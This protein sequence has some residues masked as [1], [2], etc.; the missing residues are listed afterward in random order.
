MSD[1]ATETRQKPRLSTAQMLHLM[2]LEVER[3]LRQRYPISCL[4]FGLDGFVDSELLLHRKTLMPLLFRELKAVTFERDI[5][6][7]GIWTEGFVL[8]VFP[9][10]APAALQ[11]LAQALLERAQRITAEGLPAGVAVSVSI[12]ISHNLH[13]GE[14]S[15]ATLVEDAEGGMGLARTGG[16]NRVGEWRAVETE[17]DRL[18]VELEHQIKEIS[19]V[20]ERVFAGQKEEE[21]LWGRNLVTKVLSLFQ[22]DPDQSEA[23]LRLEKE[24]VALLKVELAAWSETSSASKLLES[25]KQIENLERRITKLTESLSATEGALKQIAAAKNID[26]GVASIF[27]NV[28]GLTLEDA[29]FEAKREMLKNIFEANMALRAAITEK[30]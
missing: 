27:R 20:Q 26:L 11:E 21:D 16:G 14:V 2:R 30:T 10:V 8:A 15:F 24:V 29:M 1:T 17:L 7:L 12:G 3:A 19:A 18:K 5:R 6:G 28:Q 9:H 23:V 25:Q 22:G 13:P 4:M